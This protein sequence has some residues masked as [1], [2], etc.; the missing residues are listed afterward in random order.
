MRNLSKITIKL[1]VIVPSIILFVRCSEKIDLTTY[2]KIKVDGKYGYI[3]STGKII[4]QPQYLKTDYFPEGLAMA[5][6]DTIFVT[7]APQDFV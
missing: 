2:Y 5:V 1:L 6:V 4:I 3:D 7:P